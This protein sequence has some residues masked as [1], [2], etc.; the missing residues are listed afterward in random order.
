MDNY[1]G[2]IRAFAFNRV[3]RYWEPCNGQVM[4]I[5]VSPEL[6]FLLG[7]TYGGDGQTTFNLPDLQGRAIVH[8]GNYQGDASRIHYEQGEMG[9]WETTRLEA[10]TV[11]PHSHS[12]QVVNAPG[13]GI[14]DPGAP[15]TQY[16]AALPEVPKVP[17]ENI[18]AFVP[19][20]RMSSPGP[21]ALN[22]I[23]EA[24]GSREHENQM[25]YLPLL[26]CI[27]TEGRLP[28]RD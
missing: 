2:E 10:A 8:A 17:N 28:R 11:P 20:A 24:G 7:T 21:L 23:A 9:G 12:C 13:T 25:P 16:L 18:N 15:G 14:L 3:P 1:I 6:F 22:T 19:G 26:L 27:A 5:A 4:S